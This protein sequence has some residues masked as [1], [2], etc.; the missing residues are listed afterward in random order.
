[1]LFI[2]RI[3]KFNNEN[4][5]VDCVNVI[6]PGDRIMKYVLNL[7]DCAEVLSKVG[8]KNA[9]IGKLMRLGVRTPPGFAVTSDAYMEF[10]KKGNVMA[11]IQQILDNL[12]DD[13]WALDTASNTIR[14]I[15]ESTPIPDDVQKEVV[16]AYNELSRRCRSVNVPVSVRSSA[17]CE[18][19]PGTSFAG[20]HETYLYVCGSNELLEKLVKCWSSLFTQRAISYRRKMGIKHENALMSVGVLK[21]VN[22]KAAGVM[23]TLNPVNGD[24]S[25]IIIE[26]SF[27]L[28][29]TVVSGAVTPDRWVVDKN[30]LE[31]HESIISPGKNIEYIIDKDRKCCRKIEVIPERSNTPC[32]TNEEVIELA[33]MGKFIEQH[34][35]SAQDIEWAVDNEESFP[36]NIYI[37]QSRPETVWSERKVQLD[38]GKTVYDFVTNIVSKKALRFF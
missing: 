19:L 18:D 14:Q 1:M 8:S 9:N 12:A 33:K 36:D 11:K 31:I 25:K 7:E 35:G 37:L 4:K 5:L 13:L 21:M 20:Q 16:T 3:E 38:L 24:S 6:I 10:V 30:T 22:A 23:F 17:T 2:S 27:G 28:G 34:F 29:E 26:G 15:I 32:L